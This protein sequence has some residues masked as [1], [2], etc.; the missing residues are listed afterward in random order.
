MNFLRRVVHSEHDHF[1]FQRN[2]ACIVDCGQNDVRIVSWATACVILSI[3]IMGVSF[4][5]KAQIVLLFILIVS[6]FS[7]FIGTVLP[8][9]EFQ[10]SRGVTGYS[11]QT[12]IDNFGP[13]WRGVGF[14]DVFGVYFPAATVSAQLF[15]IFS[16]AFSN[17]FVKFDNYLM[18]ENFRASWPEQIYRAI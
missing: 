6:L 17:F 16:N 3:I 5:T 9:T 14:F 13:A 1:E 10:R 7:Y 12:F 4:E 11:R 15:D 2:D 18:S 8:V